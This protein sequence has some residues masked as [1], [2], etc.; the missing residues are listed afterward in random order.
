M[1]NLFKLLPTMINP[2]Q[3]ERKFGFIPYAEIW[4]GRLAMIGFVSALIV[5]LVTSQGVLHFWS[6]IQTLSS[7]IVVIFVN[8]AVSLGSPRTTQFFKI[9]I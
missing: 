7:Y 3:N 1:H 8:P 2:K 5:E 4:N 6:L 9:L